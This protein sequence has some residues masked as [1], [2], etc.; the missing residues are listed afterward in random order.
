MVRRDEQ[1]Q[2]PLAASSA[3]MRERTR[4]SLQQQLDGARTQL[5]EMTEEELHRAEHPELSVPDAAAELRANTDHRRTQEPM[6]IAVD[7][8]GPAM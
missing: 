6:D 1:R 2:G 8:R 7:H 5:Q 4:R 3:K